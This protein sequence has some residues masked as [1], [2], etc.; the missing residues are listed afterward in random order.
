MDAPL[1]EQF[2]GT[3]MRFKKASTNFPPEIDLHMSEFVVLVKIAN[4]KQDGSA[5]FCVSD[6]QNQLYISKPAVS[7]V[8]NSLENKG[9]IIRRTDTVDRRK[10]KVEVTAIGSEALTKAKAY[11]ENTLDSVIA[12]F[13]EDNMKQLIALFNQLA[14]IAVDR[15]E[16]VD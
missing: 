11:L 15:N 10:I 13:G 1:R 16:K 14:E 7:Q 2:I 6:V 3:M 8:L 5:D 9:Y 12:R 4:Q